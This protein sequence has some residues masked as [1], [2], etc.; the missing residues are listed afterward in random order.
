[1]GWWR[2]SAGID[3]LPICLLSTLQHEIYIFP[4][5]PGACAAS[6]LS[7]R[8]VFNLRAVTDPFVGSPR[9]LQAHHVCT[10]HPGGRAPCPTVVA[11]SECHFQL[12]PCSKIL[13]GNVMSFSF[14]PL[15]CFFLS[16]HLFTATLMYFQGWQEESRGKGKAP[17]VF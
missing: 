14:L 13:V 7:L 8:A 4:W 15:G 6:S 11:I 10:S 1:M 5:E 16:N 2:S 17:S 12:I 3:L 9:V